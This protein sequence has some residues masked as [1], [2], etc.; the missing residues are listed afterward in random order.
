MPAATTRQPDATP[1]PILAW[2]YT[3]AALVVA[4]ILV[5]GATRLTDS[6][7]SITEWQPITGVIPPLTEAQWLAAFEKYKQIPEYAVVN[8]GM[9]LA[10]FK[11]IYWWEWG[12]RFLGRFIGLAFIVPFIVFWVRRQIPA[13]LMPRLIL[14]LVLGGLQGAL[15]W[16]MV[17]SGLTD[18]VDVSQYRLAA[19]LGAAFVI[20]GFIL[21]TAYA[22][23]GLRPQTAQP[24][25][26]SAAILAALI[27]VQIIAGALVAGL[28]A[29]LSHNSWPLMDGRL[30]P[31][32]MF[33]M[34]PWHLNLFENARTV[35]FD[36][37]VLAYL[38]WLA[39]VAHAARLTRAKAAARGGAMLL[40]SLVTV[41]AITGIW[42]LVVVVPL[43]LGL[44]HQFGAIIVF[45]AALAHLA[46]LSPTSPAATAPAGI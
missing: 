29:G 20:L 28:D 15:G 37:R 35:Q 19:H 12:H 7:L 24:G 3:L 13:W 27:F 6:G 22:A 25:R 46:A 4:M 23:S 1:W 31:P 40:A 45:V 2:L 26:L 44:L 42:T 5:G 18:R 9:S 41:Q 16:F 36:H 8:P 10:A 43:S 39:A 21:W 33:V 32:D 14:I 38:V 11:V 30:V 17:M 34:T